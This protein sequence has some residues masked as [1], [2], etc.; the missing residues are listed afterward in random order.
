MRRSFSLPRV[1]LTITTLL[2]PIALLSQPLWL[3]RSHDKTVALEILKPDFDDEYNTTFTSSLAVF[4]SLRYPIGKKVLLVAELPFVHSKAE[5]FG[6][7]KSDNSIGNPYLGLEIRGEGSPFFAEVG[8]RAP[9]T[10]EEEDGELNV[11]AIVG[12]MIDQVDRLEAFA[13]DYLPITGMVNYQHKD[14]SGFVFRLRSGPAFLIDTDKQEREDATESFLLYSAQAGYESKQI[15]VD[16]GLSGR[17]WLTTEEY[18]TFGERTIHQFG[19]TTSIGLG[20]VR[21]GLQIRLPLDKDLTEF[22]D[23]VFGVNLGIH[24]K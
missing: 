6:Y 11:A 13:P 24:L 18:D 22:L 1:V 3:D 4:L 23:L 12:A 16:A 5:F 7:D 17:W 19:L 10:Q 15:S 2:F 8:V 21:P 14:P 20:I 9:L